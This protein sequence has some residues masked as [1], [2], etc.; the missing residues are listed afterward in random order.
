MKK[1]TGCKS[2]YWLLT[3]MLCALIPLSGVLLQI[4]AE[5]TEEPQVESSDS[6][7]SSESKEE[8]GGISE[9]GEGPESG[10]T[11]GSDE[12]PD[13]GETSEKP[14]VS[15]KPDDGMIYLTDGALET[16]NPQ[17]VDEPK[18]VVT[19]GTLRF[20][21]GGF[22]PPD[23]SGEDPFRTEASNGDSTESS[24]ATTAG[25]S[26][27]SVTSAQETGTEKPDREPSSSESRIARFA[28][29]VIF[30]AVAVVAV[31]F[32]AGKQFGKKR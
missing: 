14:P 12:P 21:E 32:F 31:V 20:E 2:G 28:V 23:T 6:N 22:T 1:K 3:V 9:S 16:R 29:L 19:K 24:A 11:S 7:D 26:S 10:D 4:H 8:S 27:G 15:S 17:R 25:S 13:S 18:D 5:E 30:L